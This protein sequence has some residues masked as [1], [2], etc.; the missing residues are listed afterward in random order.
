[1]HE[2]SQTC[3]A[4]YLEVPPGRIRRSSSAALWKDLDANRRWVESAAVGNKGFIH[5]ICISEE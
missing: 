3:S 2:G 1:L 5:A 4:P